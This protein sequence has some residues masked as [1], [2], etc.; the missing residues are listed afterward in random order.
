M[1]KLPACLSLIPSTAQSRGQP[2]ARRCAAWMAALTIPVFLTGCGTFFKLEKSEEKSVK[3]SPVSTLFGGKKKGGGYYLDDGPGDNPPADLHLIPDAVP[4]EEPLRASTMRPYSA[5]GK[6]YKP[7]TRHERYKTRGMASWYGRRYH[8]QKTASGEVYDM[9]AMTA[10]HP[11]LP[12]PSYARVTSVTSGKSVVVRVNDR[13]PFLSN[14]LIDLSYTAAYKLDVLGGGSGLVEVES[15]VPGTGSF[16]QLATAA[17]AERPGSTSSPSR[18]LP[19]SPTNLNGQGIIADQSVTVT[20]PTDPDSNEAQPGLF[21]ASFAPAVA[22]TPP[23]PSL[24]GEGAPGSSPETPAAV[25]AG[26]YLQL[27]AFNAYDNADNFVV[28]M[29]NELPSLMTSLDIVAKDGL[30]KVHAGPYPDRA[31]ARKAA[32]KIAEALSIKPVLLMR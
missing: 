7:M 16:T 5:L 20:P 29:R 27:G 24:A 13:G 14:R 10:A 12:I 6:R 32:D 31:L 30:F 23:G 22:D 15:I 17:S 1:D 4:R 28:R 3:P 26:I 8:G 9:Y 11:T 21:Q 25:P 2:V 19:G 18:F